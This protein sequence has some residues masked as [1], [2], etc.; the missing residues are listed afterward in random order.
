[1]PTDVVAIKREHIE[2]FVVLLNET[3]SA[4]TA[5]NRYRAL[6]Q[7]FKW[8]EAEGEIQQSPMLS[9][10]PP[11]L[12]GQIVPVIPLDDLRKLLKVCEGQDFASRRAPALI[13]FMIDTG[14]RL[15]EVA[16][17]TIDSVDFDTEVAIVAGKGRRNPPLPMGTK[18]LV[19]MSRYR[20][21][22]SRHKAT[23]SQW[24]WLGTR[25]RS[26]SS[27]IAQMLKRRSAVAGINPIHPHQF[28]HS[29][30][31]SFLSQEAM[32]ATLCAWQDGS[33]ETWSTVMRRAPLRE[34]GKRTA[35]PLRVRFFDL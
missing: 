6:Q 11:K 12:E 25:G 10:Q 26:T 24:W 5:N 18:T 15:A 1:M 22:R 28:R 20:R 9:M 7:F 3:R 34:Q 35:N 19:S 27:G 16:D 30:A 33:H 23:D 4:S 29:F 32:K 13:R 31:H 21:S 17:L 2:S 14:A 8:L